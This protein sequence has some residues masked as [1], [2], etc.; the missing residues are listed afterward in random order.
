METKPCNQ[1][2]L[3]ILSEKSSTKQLVFRETKKMYQIFEAESARIAEELNSNICN[4]DNTVVVEYKNVSDFEGQLHF[5]GDV[6]VLNMHSNV[7]TFEEDHLIWKSSYI[8]EDP[9]RAYFGVIRIY[10]FLADSFKQNRT[11]DY[12][13]LMGRIFINKD[14]HFFMEGAKQFAF[15]Y[16]NVAQDVFDEEKMREIIEQ[17]MILSLDFDLTVPD[18]NEQSEITV[19]QIQQI[20]SLQ[21]VS[22]RKKLG[23]KFKAENDEMAI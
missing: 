17:S 23:F 13:H 11:S 15:K 21:S 12:G 6:I 20:G 19:G 3:Q 2:I 7:F 9:M 4:I 8:K 14:K 1:K 22:T 16:N 10:N 5:S 18:F